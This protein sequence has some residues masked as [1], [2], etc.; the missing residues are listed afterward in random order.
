[1][2]AAGL[3][4]AVKWLLSIVEDASSLAVPLYH[5]LFHWTD[6]KAGS[7]L[8]CRVACLHGANLAARKRRVESA[9]TVPAELLHGVSHSLHARPN[10]PPLP[11]CD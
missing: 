5:A 1:M 11:T 8:E 6:P 9:E 7:A 4:Q 3:G 2:Y 10:S